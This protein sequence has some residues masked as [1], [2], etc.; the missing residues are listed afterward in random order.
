MKSDKS[1]LAW[2]V[3][4]HAINWLSLL[5]YGVLSRFSPSDEGGIDWYRRRVRPK[6]PDGPP[7]TRVLVHAVSA[8]ETKVA[9][10]LVRALTR[11]GLEPPVYV[12]TTTH[13]GYDRIRSLDGNLARTMVMPIDTI[14]EQKR[15][16]EE[17]KP[18]LLVLVESEYWP[19]QFAMAAEHDVPVIVIN[20][21]LSERSL[22]MHRRFPA[23]TRATVRRAHHIYAQD[24]LTAQRYRQLDIFTDRVEV[25][26]NLKLAGA[27][28]FEE[29]EEGER[30]WVT[31]GNV[32]QSEL[33]TLGPAVREIA[34]TAP[35]MLLPRYPGKIAP[36]VLRRHFGDGLQIVDHLSPARGP[37]QVVW[38]DKMGVLANA[39]RR[40]TVG[41]V[42]GTFARIGGHDLSEPLQQGAMSVY[43]PHVDRQSALDQSL[44]QVDAVTPVARAA[45]L[46]P[47][48]AA[49]M[50]DPRERTARRERFT[51]LV[52]ET[53]T[54]L[55]RLAGELRE[56]AERPRG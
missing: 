26:G 47:A 40:S 16:F 50:A 4:S 2:S 43:G 41:V 7:G 44:R 52:H 10:L 15:L 29:A 45:E 23:L 49:L 54:Q 6:L 37:G 27:S 13:S 56:V 31:F 3:Y 17:L 12:S 30:P 33:A 25:L 24:E 22:R 11:A 36:E 35:V 8:G 9:T 46:P 20:A 38:V 32:H 1:A 34:R 21:T 42:C 28:L 5:H 14:K 55:E 18:T 51:A 19:A 53:E 48:V 39:Y